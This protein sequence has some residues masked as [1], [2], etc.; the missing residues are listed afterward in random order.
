MEG[1]A[2]P[3]N[4]RSFRGPGLMAQSMFYCLMWREWHSLFGV[5]GC[6]WQMF[7]LQK[8][9]LQ[10]SQTGLGESLCGVHDTQLS[11]TRLLQHVARELPHLVT[12]PDLLWRVSFPTQY[13]QILLQCRPTQISP[14]C[15]YYYKRFLQMPC[16][17][18][19]YIAFMDSI[20]LRK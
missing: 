4:T 15:S 14:S 9:G 6:I 8:H 11:T 1:F 16:S 13:K 12:S 18:Q 20:G 19:K 2:H 5:Q 17:N 10:C 7:A 3:I